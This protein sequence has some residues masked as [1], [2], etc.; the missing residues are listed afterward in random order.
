MSFCAKETPFVQHK[1]LFASGRWYQFSFAMQMANIG[2]DVGR[3][4]NWK[5][6]EN[7]LKSEAALFRAL[8]LID[9]T[10]IDPRLHK[11]GRRR[12]LGRVRECLVDYFFADN[13]YG[14]SDDLLN[15]YFMYFAYIAAAER[16]R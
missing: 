5:K 2:A 7:M 6:D 1:N 9:Y 3:A 14:S 15:N 16:G 8:E 11:T 4:I 10:I 12:E 13:Q